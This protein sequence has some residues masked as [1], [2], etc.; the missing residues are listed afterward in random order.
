M[1][2][3]KNCKKMNSHSAFLQQLSFFNLIF[4]SIIC[5]RMTFTKKYKLTFDRSAGKPSAN[6]SRKK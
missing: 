4:D 1:P 3:I 6:Q 2:K 5:N